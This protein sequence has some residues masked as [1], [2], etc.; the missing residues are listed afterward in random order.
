[1]RR[2]LKGIVPFEVLERPRKAYLLRGPLSSLQH[3]EAPIRNL[4]RAPRIA[5]LGLVNLPNL[6]LALETL[7]K[8][9]D[10]CNFR[11]L[12][13]AIALELWLRSIDNASGPIIAAA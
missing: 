12:T 6:N 2:A 10:T 4:F 8:G 7:L 11:S 3:A 5:G 1:M 13:R 9:A